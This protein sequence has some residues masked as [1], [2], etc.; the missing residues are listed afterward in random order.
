MLG[1]ALGT[2]LLPSLSKHHATRSADVY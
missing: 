1:V 2:I